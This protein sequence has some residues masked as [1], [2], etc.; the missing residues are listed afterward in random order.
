MTGRTASQSRCS[1]ACLAACL[2][3]L[4]FDLIIGFTPPSLPEALSASE[5]DS[6]SMPPLGKGVFL[7]ASPNLSDP[8]FHQTVILLCEYGPEGAL[9]VIVNRP[10]EVLLSEALPTIAVLK[11]TSYVLFAGGPV[12]Q[13][14]ILML[15]RVAQAP[16]D[17]RQVMEGIY[18][19]GSMSTLER[20][21]TQ[22][23]PTETF[24]AFAGYAGWAPGQLEMEMSVGSWAT[25]KADPISVFDKDP[26]N[27][28]PELLETLRRPGVVRSIKTPAP[29]S[30]DPLSSFPGLASG[31]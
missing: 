18:L 3:L 27:L 11:G 8:N 14:G 26:A 19:G 13:G 31:M 10:T 21:I 17:T 9:G 12:Q 16:A 1:F 4:L 2:A 7:V 24:R 30:A 25:V 22:P 29:V 15:F 5:Y 23:Q 20:V 28:W 6:N